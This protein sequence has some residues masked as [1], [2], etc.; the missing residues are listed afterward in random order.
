M[1][2]SIVEYLFLFHLLQKCTNCARNVVVIIKNKVPRFSMIDG[3][4]KW[5]IYYTAMFYLTDCF[6]CA[7]HAQV[8]FPSVN[9]HISEDVSFVYFKQAV[10]SPR[11][12]QLDLHVSR[13][14]QS[15]HL[16]QNP[17]GAI[18]TFAFMC[19]F[20]L[21]MTQRNYIV[22]LLYVTKTQWQNID[23]RQQVY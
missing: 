18:P 16:L 22:M 3:V 6:I 15:N 13:I 19:I 7:A 17:P 2:N 5:H 23:Q 11:S 21:R 10:I 1:C 8:A 4:H 9:F 14:V 12:P 20:C